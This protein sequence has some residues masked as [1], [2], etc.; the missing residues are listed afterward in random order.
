MNDRVSLSLLATPPHPCPYLEDQYSRL[1][2]LAPSPDI[3]PEAL[4]PAMLAAGFRRNGPDLYRPECPSC[5]ACIPLRIPVQQ[6]R[7][8]RQQRR[9]LQRNQDIVINIEEVRV[10]EEH[11]Q[12]YLRY[13]R[14]RH[15]GDVKSDETLAD[16]E[17]F[18]QSGW[19]SGTQLMELRHGDGTLLA[20]AMLDM[21]RVAMSAVYT[22]YAP[23]VPQR[24]LGTLSVLMQI[25]LAAEWGMAWLYLGYWISACR[26]MA[27]KNRFLPAEILRD[28]VWSPLRIAED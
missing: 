20:V 17:R 16:F 18:I 12:L 8:D 13:L 19:S 2:F 21:T 28:G 11:Y 6:F 5:S 24:S 25:R 14:A 3:N 7:P 26:K 23:E 1:V 22:W 15:P 10:F 27:Y 4:Y 9:T